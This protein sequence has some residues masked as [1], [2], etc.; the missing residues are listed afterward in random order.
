[1]IDPEGG[2]PLPS[3]RVARVLQSLRWLPSIVGTRRPAASRSWSCAAGRACSP[4]RPASRQTILFVAANPRGTTRFALEAECAAIECELRIALGRDD[5]D[6]RSTWAVTIDELMRQL[7][8]HQPTIVHFSGQGAR[9]G[10][11]GEPTGGVGIHFQQGG[12]SQYV[13]ERALARM[14][15]TAAPS[16]RV[17]VLNACFSDALA[18]PL[19]NLVD[20]VVGMGGAISDDAARCFAVA[21]YRALGY[22]CSIGNAVAQAIATLVAK[23]FPDEQ[24]PVCRTRDGIDAD[25][26]FLPLS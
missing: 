5:F 23:Q 13:S 17:V 9:S 21:F 26:L 11:D 14:I 22:W 8:E 2:F 1:V 6:F 19:R 4:R 18:E 15:A 10:G 16:T 20:C 12:E 24:V 25:Q 7:N 3:H